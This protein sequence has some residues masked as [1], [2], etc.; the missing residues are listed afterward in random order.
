MFTKG[1]LKII[2][3]MGKENIILVKIRM[4]MKENFNMELKKEKAFILLI[5]ILMMDIGIM[6]YLVV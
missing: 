3:F 5:N 4:N 1:I 2:Y 6:I